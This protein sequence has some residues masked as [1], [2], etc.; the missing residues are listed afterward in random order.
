GFEVRERLAEHALGTLSGRERPPVD[1]HLDWWGG[2]R[3]E[4]GELREAAGSLGFAL[5]PATPAPELEDLVVAKVRSAAGRAHRVPK[6]RAA[7]LALVAALIAVAGLGWGA[8]MAGNAARYGAQVREVKESQQRAI[9]KL[10]LVLTSGP[11]ADASNRS[12]IGRLDPT[13][14]GSAGGAALEL[15]SPTGPDI[16]MVMVTGL[17]RDGFP[18]YS[19]S[20]VNDRGTDLKV[21]DISS[22]DPGG[23]AVVSSRFSVSLSGFNHIV[24][25]DARG[26]EMLGGTVAAQSSTSSS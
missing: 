10:S 22:L 12:L 19:V 7:A 23:G 1:R 24:V 3:K 5:P 14:G 26:V 20:V 15:L 21:G 4:A 8:V 6:G 25:T 2:C 11:W 9:Q 13:R 17:P 18:P 16:A